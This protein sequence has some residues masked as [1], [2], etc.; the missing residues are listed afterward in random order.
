[1]AA[2]ALSSTAAA[3]ASDTVHCSAAQRAEDAAKR[4]A[5]DQTWFVDRVLVPAARDG[6]GLGR[7]RRGGWGRLDADLLEAAESVKLGPDLGDPPAGDAED[8]DPG[9]GH[10]DLAGYLA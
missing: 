5:V 2:W 8:V 3:T 4:L 1:M 6:D 7:N 10:C 9:P